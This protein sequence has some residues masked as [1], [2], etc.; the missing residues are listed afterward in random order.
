MRRERPNT[1]PWHYVDIPVNA[2]TFDRKRD[3]RDGNNV[4]D[5]IDKQAKILADTT[6]TKGTRAEALKFL[7]HFVGDIHQPLHCADRN[8]DKGGN[9]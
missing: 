2:H 4:I 6:A 3:G 8:G 5:A 1:A 7:V 9:T